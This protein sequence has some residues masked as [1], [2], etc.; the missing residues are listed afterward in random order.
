MKTLVCC[1]HMERR[2]KSQNEGALPVKKL[3]FKRQK[4]A[5]EEKEA[6]SLET[7][8]GI[9]TRST[10][11]LCNN[12]FHPP[13]CENQDS[14]LK[15]GRR[16]KPRH[17]RRG[18][19]SSSN[20][21]SDDDKRTKIAVE[22]PLIPEFISVTS[23]PI[24][25]E[26]CAKKDIE[27]GDN[28]CTVKADMSLIPYVSFGQ[29]DEAL[30]AFNL[31]EIED[32]CQ[33]N[34]PPCSNPTGDS[35]LKHA[36]DVTE[37]PSS[38]FRVPVKSLRNTG[39]VGAVTGDH[40]CIVKPEL[41]AGHPESISSRGEKFYG[42]PFKVKESLSKHRGIDELYGEWRCRKLYTDLITIYGTN[43]THGL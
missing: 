6:P 31:T 43:Q 18:S 15:I 13:K 11:S 41:S 28:Y 29:D 36:K 4:L 32:S 27:I 25:N 19:H 22:S 1:S 26:C 24:G 2:R 16:S 23:T 30:A 17:E 5:P 8:V 33:K 21:D 34:D 38:M 10:R 39:V 35:N 7:D 3:F 42:L 12:E 20:C 37:H 14:T 40:M 9:C